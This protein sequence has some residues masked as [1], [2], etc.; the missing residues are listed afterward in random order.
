[1]PILYPRPIYTSNHTYST[2]EQRIPCFCLDSGALV[3]EGLAHFDKA[4][5]DREEN[6]SAEN[7]N[8]SE[9]KT[10]RPRDLDDPLGH[11]LD[12]RITVRYKLST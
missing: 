3:P 2:Q 5:L 7:K 11:L 10:K 1:M 12:E 9:E 8:Y 4:L 6:C